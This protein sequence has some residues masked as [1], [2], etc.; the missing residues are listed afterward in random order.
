M[1]DA[2][3]RFSIRAYKKIT[4]TIRD[5]VRGKPYVD[6]PDYSQSQQDTVVIYRISETGYPKV[7]PT[8]VNNETCLRNATQVFK[9]AS[10]RWL[11]LADSCTGETIQMIA[12]YVNPNDIV[13]VKVGHGAGTFQLA[14]KAVQALSPDTIVYFLEN[15]YLHTENSYLALREG[16]RFGDYVTLYDHPDMYTNLRH[17]PQPCRVYSGTISHWRSAPSTTM[18]FATRAGTAQEDMRILLRWTKGRHPY[19]NEM[20]LNLRVKGRVLVSPIPSFS[21]H[22]ETAFLAPRI[23]WSSCV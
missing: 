11:V 9:A 21:T 15:D 13:R 5:Q 14:L 22:G 4:T 3:V 20:F 19:D 17:R 1:R 7:K 16:L 6:V 8:Y 23:D 12:K 18:T 10:I 2:V